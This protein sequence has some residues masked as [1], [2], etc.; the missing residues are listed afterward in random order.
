VLS[1]VFTSSAIGLD[2][3]RYLKSLEIVDSQLNA[4][5]RPTVTFYSIKIPETVYQIEIFAQPESPTSTVS[6]AGGSD[7]QPGVNYAVVTVT[8][9]NGQSLDYEIEI[10]K[11]GVVY[12]TDS[13]LRML[14]VEGYEFTPAF[15]SDVLAYSLDVFSEAQRIEIE[16]I[17]NS[18]LASVRIENDENLA[19]GMN[20]VTI[21]VISE[22]GLSQTEYFLHVNKLDEIDEDAYFDYAN[23]QKLSQYAIPIIGGLVLLFVATG[24]IVVI[25]RK[26]RAGGKNAQ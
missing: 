11:A 8:A 13:K 16:A 3:N 23:T 5:F 19:S 9:E 21:T 18:S 17:P 6:I 25:I 2:E 26:K 22:D 10:T 7:L 4:P 12:S 14:H 24:I 1:W 20:V 15:R